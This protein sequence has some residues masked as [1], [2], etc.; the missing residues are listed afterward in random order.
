MP[1]SPIK[2]LSLPKPEKRLP[3]FL[4]VQQMNDLLAAPQNP[5]R[6]AKRQKRRGTPGFS[7]PSALRDVA[8]LE[9]IY[10]CGLRISELCGLRADDIDWSQQI[11]R[12]RG[13]GKKERL[14]PIGKPALD[15]IER[16]WK[17]LKQPPAGASPVFFSETKSM[18]RC[19]PSN[20]HDG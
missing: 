15:A 1:A 17:I 20:F 6:I 16:Y 7:P 12:V 8:V 19:I 10:S 18:R 5:W 2:N 14:V 9:T 3:K 13:K 11:V 4:T